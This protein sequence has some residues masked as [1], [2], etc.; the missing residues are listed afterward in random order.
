MQ[1]PAPPL[2]IEHEAAKLR[3]L[4][5]LSSSAGTGSI[6]LDPDLPISSVASLQ[7]WEDSTN[8][9]ASDRTPAPSDD[10]DSDTSHL[11][12]VPA[13]LHPELAPAGFLAFPREHASSAPESS[14]KDPPLRRDMSRPTSISRHEPVLS[15][16]VKPP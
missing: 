11:F 16:Q 5:R 8:N 3:T 1:A 12:W 9:S 4:R 15:R 2:A 13:H 7:S 10:S 14:D 6:P